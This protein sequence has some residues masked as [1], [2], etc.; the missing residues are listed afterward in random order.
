MKT[1]DKYT[2][3]ELLALP[4]RKWCE[5]ATYDYALLVN[6]RTKHDSGFNLFAVIGFK[7]DQGEIAGYMDD[8]RLDPIYL[9]NGTADKFCF[10]IDCSM[11]GVFRI[12]GGNKIIVGTN[13]STTYFNFEGGKR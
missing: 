4:R 5:S 10:A 9:F 13:T 11:R 7:G 12:H 1:W 8:F 3:K 6:T 2:K